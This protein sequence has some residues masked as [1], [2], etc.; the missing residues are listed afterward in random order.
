MRSCGIGVIAIIPAL[1]SF[2]TYIRA[3]VLAYND[4]STNI[5][6]IRLDIDSGKYYSL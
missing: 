6:W 1:A 3:I 4:D 5:V 2:S